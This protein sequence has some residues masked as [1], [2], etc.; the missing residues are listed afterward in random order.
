MFSFNLIISIM[1]FDK[2]SNNKEGLGE[3]KY[4][5]VMEYS[6]DPSSGMQ[7]VYVLITP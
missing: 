3:R 6:Q 7:A 1:L 5:H 2:R 4:D